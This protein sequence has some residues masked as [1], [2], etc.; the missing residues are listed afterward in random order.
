[1][2]DKFT[3]DRLMIK[4]KKDTLEENLQSKLYLNYSAMFL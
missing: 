1:M 3:D 2:K 4:N